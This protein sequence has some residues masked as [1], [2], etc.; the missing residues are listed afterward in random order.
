MQAVLGYRKSEVEMRVQRPRKSCVNIA[1]EMD[2]KNIENFRANRR[3]DFAVNG[4]Q[5]G[6]SIGIP[7]AKERGILIWSA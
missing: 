7:K 1:C 4:V 3:E 5:G 2:K 6:F